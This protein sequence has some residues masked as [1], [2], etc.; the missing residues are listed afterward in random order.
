MN[1]EPD[2]MN[3]CRTMSLVKSNSSGQN[4][5]LII[6]RFLE[7]FVGSMS[8]GQLTWAYAFVEDLRSTVVNL[9]YVIFI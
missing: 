7:T 1:T 8:A 4:F 3:F 2:I 9:F 6:V 5:F